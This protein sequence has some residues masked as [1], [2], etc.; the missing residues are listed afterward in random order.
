MGVWGGGWAWFDTALRGLR[1]GSP[2]ADWHPVGR[3]RAD[4]ATRAGWGEGAGVANAGVGGDQ[5][6]VSGCAQPGPLGGS[7]RTGRTLDASC[8]EDWIP[9]EDA[10][11]TG[12]GG[13]LESGW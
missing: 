11:M 3:V 13:G 4:S 2:R 7:P 9:A 12:G 8:A 5:A 6:R 1:A 10:G